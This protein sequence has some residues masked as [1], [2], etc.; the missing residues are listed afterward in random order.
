MTE[1]MRAYLAGLAELE[2]LTAADLDDAAVFVFGAVKERAA[3]D[4]D[5]AMRYLAAYVR[6]A[7]VR[8]EDAQAAAQAAQA[9][10]A[11]RMGERP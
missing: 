10:S 3:D 5:G 1:T 8:V 9:E 11:L 4:C 2:T 6:R 7:M